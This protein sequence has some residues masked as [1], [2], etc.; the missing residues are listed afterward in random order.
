MS[1]HP[2]WV[3]PI[4][5]ASGERSL[6]PEWQR[7]SGERNRKSAGRRKTAV[8]VGNQCHSVQPHGGLSQPVRA[9][10]GEGTRTIVSIRSEIFSAGEASRLAGVSWRVLDSWAKTE[11]LRPSIR[12]ARGTGSR[13]TYSFADLV[14]LAAVQNLRT[15]GVELGTL[16]P[17]VRYLQQRE[18]LERVESGTLLVLEQGTVREAPAPPAPPAPAAARPGA[19]SEAAVWLLFDLSRV[20]EQLKQEIA[21]LQAAE[22]PPWD[23]PARRARSSLGETAAGEPERS[24]IG[25]PA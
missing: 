5:T 11:F 21:R 18:E 19:K 3:P 9:G 8:K 24:R 25:P 10:E 13:R 1:S 22:R 15:A 23:E 2:S 20:I 17:V 16:K 7:P 14:A 4:L 6:L 12:Q